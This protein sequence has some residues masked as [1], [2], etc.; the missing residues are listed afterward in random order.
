MDGFEGAHHQSCKATATHFRNH[1]FIR[2]FIKFHQ[3]P[4]WTIIC[5]YIYICMCRYILYI[6]WM[7]CV[8]VIYCS[9]G[10]FPWPLIENG[11]EK[12]AL[13]TSA[14]SPFLCSCFLDWNSTTRKSGRGPKSQ[15]DFN[16][17]W[18]LNFE[19]QIQMGKM[20]SGAPASDSR[21]RAR[22]GCP[23]S[24]EW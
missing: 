19:V 15:V 24:W 20:T 6:Y 22:L 14:H 3:I 10:G 8:H 21:A 17:S 7:F 4:K 18:P 13:Q 2:G 5:I 11:R 12:C 16:F 1:D 23:A 9:A